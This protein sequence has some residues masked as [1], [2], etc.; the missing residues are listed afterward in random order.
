MNIKIGYSKK[1]LKDIGCHKINLDIYPIKVIIFTPDQTAKLEKLWESDD[2]TAV[3]RNYTAK[4]DE[5]WIC[6][7]DKPCYETIAH[8]V[9]H[10]VTMIMECIGHKIHGEAD[11]PSAYLTGYLVREIIKI[12]RKKKITIK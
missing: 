8:E 12:F 11:E 10:A 4:H 1:I 6:F 7:M 5:V 2:Y 9:H 3:T